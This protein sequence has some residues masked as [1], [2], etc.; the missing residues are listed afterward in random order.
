MNLIRTILSKIAAE[1]RLL[2]VGQ[3]ALREVRFAKYKI[4]PRKGDLA[5]QEHLLRRIP[6]RLGNRPLSFGATH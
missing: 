5:I 2:R 6:L 4:A 3:H 1:F